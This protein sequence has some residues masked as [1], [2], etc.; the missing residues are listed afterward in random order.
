MAEPSLH[1]RPG[2]GRHRGRATRVRLAALAALLLILSSCA[3]LEQFLS[4]SLER[5]TAQVTGVEISDLTFREITLLFDLEITN[6]NQVEVNLAGFDYDFAVEERPFLRGENR[7]GLLIPGMES[8]TVELP[9][10]VTYQELLQTVD[11]LTDD[12]ESPYSLEV[13]FSFDLPGLGPVRVSARRDG[14]IPVVE[15]PRVALG[16][17]RLEAVDFAG[18][19]MLLMVVIENPNNF[20]GRIEELGF[21]FAVDG[22]PWG[23]GELSGGYEVPPTGRVEVELPVYVNFLAVGGS[24]RRL[25]RGEGEFPYTLDGSA[26]IAPQW[27]LLDSRR[28][29]FDLSGTARVR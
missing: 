1:H 29:D 8:S 11:N 14:T 19:S 25:L 2:A 12:R 22:R 23:E 24:A 18:A 6:P 15:L 26:V 28:F 17:L 16:Q 27:E 5:P 9:V 13:G 10:T 7:D 21:S 4:G 3:L 20:G